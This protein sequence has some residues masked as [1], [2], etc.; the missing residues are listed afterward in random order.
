MSTEKKL[1][2]KIKD[3]IIISKL[4]NRV[5]LYYQQEHKGI[6]EEQEI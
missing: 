3:I 5:F 6:I 4:T 1:R 2:E